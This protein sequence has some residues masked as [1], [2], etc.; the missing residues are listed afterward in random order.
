MIEHSINKLL[1]FDIETV[2]M[3]PDL[4]SLE[5]NYPEHYRLFINY[6]DWFRRKYN[7][8]ENMDAEEIYEN[9]SALI[10]EFGKIV[11][12]SFS[13]ITPKGDI[14]TQTFSDDDEKV[15][16]LQIKDILEKVYTLDFHLCGHNIKN[17]DIPYLGKKFLSNG[18]KPPKILPSY[19]TKPWEIKAIDTKELW[20]FSSNYGLSS[21]DL[22]SVSM[23]I[24]SPKTGSLSGKDV[25]SKYWFDREIDKISQYCEEDV[26]SLLQIIKK[27]Y[28]LK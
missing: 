28:N 21:L 20:G 24:E 3:T 14:H 23:G 5:E 22:M 19:S 8:T 16:L 25:H 11:C 12:A 9:K 6:L 2:G 15:L 26:K 18:I 1:F 10:P 13:F 27:I 17:F 7:D 4:N